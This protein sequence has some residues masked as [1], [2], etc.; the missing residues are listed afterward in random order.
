VFPFPSFC[1]SDSALSDNSFGPTSIFKVCFFNP[2]T[3]AFTTYSLPE[4]ITSTYGTP[5]GGSYSTGHSNPLKGYHGIRRN[6]SDR[7]LNAY[8]QLDSR[9]L[10][11]SAG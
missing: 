4:S 10:T 9:P 8:I 7:L 6:G 1:T 3:S 5:V 2:G 11:T